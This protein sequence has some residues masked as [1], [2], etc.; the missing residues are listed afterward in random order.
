M[1]VHMIKPTKCKQ[2][3]F[4]LPYGTAGG[5]DNYSI[6]PITCTHLM[7]EARAMAKAAGS[8]TTLTIHAMF[9]KKLAEHLSIE[10]E[11]R[12]SEELNYLIIE[13]YSHEI[14][15]LKKTLEPSV[16]SPSS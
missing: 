9:K 12:I 7:G 6:S 1:E 13:A 4:S 16:V 8:E 14:E 15:E 3:E 10:P 5:E 11:D 2:I